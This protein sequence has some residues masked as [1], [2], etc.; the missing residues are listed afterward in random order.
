VPVPLDYCSSAGLHRPL[1]PWRIYKFTVTPT[2]LLALTLVDMLVR[3][4]AR[5]VMVYTSGPQQTWRPKLMIVRWYDVHEYR[6]NA[7]YGWAIF[8]MAVLFLM[9]TRL[10]PRVAVSE[11]QTQSAA[12]RGRIL[13]VLAAAAAIAACCCEMP[14]GVSNLNPYM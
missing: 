7:A 14:G 6:L 5:G 13:I 8:T 9:L 11:R 2:V 3:Y 12:R 10:G 1:A 4:S